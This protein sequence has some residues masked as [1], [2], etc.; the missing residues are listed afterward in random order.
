MHITCIICWNSIVKF[1]QNSVVD[2]IFFTHFLQDHSLSHLDWHGSS[3]FSVEFEKECMTICSQVI[4]FWLYSP[5]LPSNSKPE[6]DESK[7]LA[8]AAAIPAQ[9][10]V[11]HDRRRLQKDDRSSIA[12]SKPPIGAL[13]AAATPAATPAVV[14]ER[15]QTWI[16]IQV[17]DTNTPV[18][19]ATPR[20]EIE[21]RLHQ[22]YR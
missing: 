11:C 21:L 5:K 15:L 12:N 13:N 8:V 20:Y 17:S 19:P 7:S 6:K 10:K 1:G 9:K 3:L 2:G 18:A 4:T 16:T 14:N 22:N